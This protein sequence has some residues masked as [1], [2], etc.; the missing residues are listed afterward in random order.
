MQCFSSHAALQ[1]RHT[2]PS[3]IRKYSSSPSGLVDKRHVCISYL[4]L[5]TCVSVHKKHTRIENKATIVLRCFSFYSKQS[6]LIFGKRITTLAKRRFSRGWGG[7]KVFRCD[8]YFTWRCSDDYFRRRSVCV[9][10]S[11]LWESAAAAAAAGGDLRVCSL[12]ELMTPPS[13]RLMAPLTL[14][15]LGIII[16][17]DLGI[18]CHTHYTPSLVINHGLW[19]VLWVDLR[20]MEVVFLIRARWL[21][22]FCLL[23]LS[24][25][26][27]RSRSLSVLSPPYL[28]VSARF[29]LLIVSRVFVWKFVEFPI[30]RNQDPSQCIPLCTHTHLHTENTT[31]NP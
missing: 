8:M 25:S 30:T 21:F 7:E 11:K 26:L 29:S 16:S 20:G 2:L 3:F 10:T 22:L 19:S 31:L 28:S 14:P 1:A 13:F 5:L 9:R 15:D 6:A 17:C 4:L 27:S 23:H 18:P 24:L 12:L